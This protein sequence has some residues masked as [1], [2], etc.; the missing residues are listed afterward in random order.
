[1]KERS[2]DIS[3]WVTETDGKTTIKTSPI[4][5]KRV[6]EE[7]QLTLSIAGVPS[8][9]TAATLF[10][11]LSTSNNQVTTELLLVEFEPYFPLNPRLFNIVHL[12]TNRLTGIEDVLEACTVI[13][14]EL[15][16]LTG[17]DRIMMYEFDKEW[18][19]DV[20]AERTAPGVPQLYL[21]LHFPATDIPPQARAL[22]LVNP[23]RIISNVD[24]K[25]SPIIPLHNPATGTPIDLSFST[26]RSVSQVHLQYIRNIN[27][28]ATLAISI[29]VNDKRSQ[30]KK[31]LWGLIVGHHRTPKFLPHSLRKMCQ[32]LSHTVS[33][34]IENLLFNKLEEKRLAMKELVATLSNQEQSSL[35][36]HPLVS[37]TTISTTQLLPSTL[38]VLRLFSAEYALVEVNGIRKLIGNTPSSET[39]FVEVFGKWIASQKI[40]GIFHSDSFV[41]SLPDVAALI[42]SPFVTAGILYVPLDQEGQN[43][44]VLFRLEQRTEVK[45]AGA[46]AKLA[47]VHPTT[48]RLALMPRASFSVWVEQVHGKAIP[49]TDL[50]LETAHTMFVHVMYLM[51]II[52][53]QTRMM[54]EVLIKDLLVRE[55]QAAEEASRA[56]GQ[57]L[58]NVSHE[59]R[60]DRT[61]LNAII[62][63]VDLT[64]STTPVDNIQSE[65]LGAVQQASE[66]LLQIINDLLDISKIE[67]GKLSLIQE[68][69]HLPQLMTEAASIYKAT[70][71]RTGILF[72][73]LLD[74]STPRYILSDS[75]RLRQVITNLLSNAQKYT[76]AGKISLTVCTAD[77]MTV[78]SRPSTPKQR[79]ECDGDK[80][81]DEEPKENTVT[82]QMDTI[83]RVTVEDT[84]IGIPKEKLEL[85]FQMFEQVDNSLTRS[86][87]GTGLGLSICAQII[88]LMGG[89]IWCESQLGEGSKLTF[90]IPVLLAPEPEGPET[91]MEVDSYSDFEN[92]PQPATSPSTSPKPSQLQEDV[93]HEATL[94]LSLPFHVLVVEDNML[95]QKVIGN[96]LRRFEV[97]ME[98]A[99]NGQIAVSRVRDLQ[100]TSFQLILMDVCMPVMDGLTATK[101]IRTFERSRDLRPTPIIALS[102]LVMTQDRDACEKA[103]M[104]GFLEKPVKLL[105]LKSIIKPMMVQSRNLRVK[106]KKSE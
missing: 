27:I 92:R 5:E 33:S 9:E 75:V 19:G 54:E 1:M 31:R 98:F 22:Y 93:S 74:P 38:S 23:L 45:W 42:K 21:G 104:N 12:A 91:Q 11:D 103:G 2:L 78:R 55:K 72:D 20:I 8:A 37:L 43:Y 95:N 53:L 7:K 47:Q 65:Y 97:T 81:N 4:G 39:E 3:L 59:V 36:D 6:G 102:A 51:R 17:F 24:Y 96:L 64:L 73:L 67:S 46:P 85:I 94:S 61:P 87:G 66:A 90:E 106:N 99:N 26:F 16:R 32:V 57:F 49:W 89:Q 71:K 30:Q 14:E 86:S 40:P 60:L 28:A 80:M 56:K 58:A 29:V 34:R 79:P 100:K 44:M 48:K 63:M 50:E 62:G 41:R 76:T 88:N 25:P 69:M 52:N 10:G 82:K 101:E 18:H 77:S 13:T 70:L 84:G 68:R 83:L 15:G 105:A 35:S